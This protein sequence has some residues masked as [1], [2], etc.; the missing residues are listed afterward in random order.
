MSEFSNPINDIEI[1]RAV[2][3]SEK[4]LRDAAREADVPEADKQRMDLA[5]ERVGQIVE[6]TLNPGDISRIK[7]LF[8]K[9]FYGLEK[10]NEVFSKQ[11]ALTEVPTLPSEE[12]LE[13]ARELGMVIVLRVYQD[14]RQ[15][16]WKIF[17]PQVLDVGK[18][19]TKGIGYVD[20]TRAI[21]DFLIDHNLITQEE[22]EECTDEKLANLAKALT[23][24]TL[25]GLQE[26]THLKVNKNHRNTIEDMKYYAAMLGEGGA[27]GKLWKDFEATTELSRYGIAK[28]GCLGR[29]EDPRCPL[30]LHDDMDP[31]TGEMSSWKNVYY[32]G[33]RIAI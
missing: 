9:D 11:L 16:E 3:Y 21:R 27:C 13:K 19:N 1:A 24:N 28:I 33:V 10:Y 8:G 14:A 26:L 22:L 25:Q 30:G 29:F 32:S 23:I 5:A 31:N 4:P 6:K 7:E 15:S 2:A 17:R 18:Y 12:K 20:Q